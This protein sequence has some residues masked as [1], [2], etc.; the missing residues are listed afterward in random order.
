MMTGD[1]KKINLI[2]L[3]CFIVL[4]VFK[5]LGHRQPLGFFKCF[6][7]RQGRVVG[8]QPLGN[9]ADVLVVGIPKSNTPQCPSTGFLLDMTRA[10]ANCD[11]HKVND[12]GTSYG[13][14]HKLIRNGNQN[15]AICSL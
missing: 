13:N 2:L 7:L 1:H 3:T 15:A 8:S 11:N 9:L 14:H 12:G 5:W 6:P 10:T 4:K